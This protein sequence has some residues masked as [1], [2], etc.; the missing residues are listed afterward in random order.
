MPF[1]LYLDED[2]SAHAL[3]RALRDKGFEVETASEAGMLYQSDENQLEYA[4]AATSALFS[5]NRA[6]FY[7][8]HTEWLSIG[9]HHSGIVLSYQRLGLG[10]TIRRLERLLESRTAEQM[11][12]QVEFL[13]P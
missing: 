4:A 6:D 10:E 13:S 7:R 8:L 9:R 2:S 1:R 5:F 3:V 11:R 12:D